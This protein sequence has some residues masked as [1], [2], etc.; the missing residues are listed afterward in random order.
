MVLCSGL[1]EPRQARRFA[2]GVA[3]EAP[4]KRQ[5]RSLTEPQGEAFLFNDLYAFASA[6][7]IEGFVDDPF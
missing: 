7:S 1:K 6:P 5:P 3:E 2:D 4:S